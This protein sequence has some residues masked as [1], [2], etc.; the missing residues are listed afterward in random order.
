VNGTPS[1]GTDGTYDLRWNLTLD[2]KD[3]YDYDVALVQ[4]LTVEIQ[5]FY[6][7]PAFGRSQN[8]SS[9]ESMDAIQGHEWFR[10]ASLR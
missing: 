1:V 3:G 9:A 2:K 7:S 8:S 5:Y 6:Q 4:E 10:R